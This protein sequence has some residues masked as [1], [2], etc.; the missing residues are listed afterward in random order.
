[1][2]LKAQ[3]LEEI[4]NYNVEARAECP[5]ELDKFGKDGRGYEARPGRTP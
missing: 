5:S 2:S 4:E 3:A 1:M